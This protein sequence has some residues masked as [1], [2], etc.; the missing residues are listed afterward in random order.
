MGRAVEPRA[1]AVLERLSRAPGA[2]ARFTLAS[3]VR[4]T[5]AFIAALDGLLLASRAESMPNVVLE[6]YAQSRPVI[7]S[8]VGDIARLVTSGESGWLVPADDV[9]ALA[10][11]IT[12]FVGA[13]DAL[14]AAMGAQG[15]ERVEADY[16][17]AQLCARTL[18][19][20]RDVMAHRADTPGAP[21][22]T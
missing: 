8:D 15:R 22:T 13:E 1:N 2:L 11:A 5:C 4:D 21:E 7:A 16:S 20:Y 19:V 10:T 9:G 3:P 14:L 17:L 12:G 6:S 18:A